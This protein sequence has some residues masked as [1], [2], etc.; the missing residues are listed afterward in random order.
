MP[1]WIGKGRDE[2]NHFFEVVGKNVRSW[3]AGFEPIISDGVAPNPRTGL[4][5]IRKM[6]PTIF[7]VK[8]VV[9][10]VLET[11][12]YHPRVWRG[13]RESPSMLNDADGSLV[14]GFQ[15]FGLL[16]DRLGAILRTVQPEGNRRAFG[17]DIRA[18]LLLAC[19][20][21]ENSWRAILIA[22][23][24][25]HNRGRWTTRDYVALRR[26]LRLSEW[27]VA[28]PLHLRYGPIRPFR[29]WRPD[30]PTR[31]LRWYHDYNETKHDRET[32]LD[33]GSL[34]SAIDAVGA[35]YVMLLA[36]VGPDDPRAARFMPRDFAVISRPSWTLREGYVPP[37]ETR[38]RDPRNP[39]TSGR[40]GVW[41]PVAHSF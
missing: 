39:R 40:V 38:P 32:N 20:E 10:A 30:A 33:R 2:Q 29:S 41:Q 24:Y 37:V 1:V 36:Q 34:A 6:A 16:V 25:S 13:E 12:Q 28:M 11:G 15:A 9:R 23:N 8:R 17:H 7:G 21:V 18:L 3:T 27:E 14:L 26:P 35:A 4:N 19:T 5:N 22:N 31:S